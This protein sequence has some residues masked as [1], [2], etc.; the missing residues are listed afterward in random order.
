[1]ETAEQKKQFIQSSQ[2]FST[3]QIYEHYTNGTYYIFAY[4]PECNNKLY[5]EYGDGYIYNHATLTIK[6]IDFI[7]TK[8]ENRVLQHSDWGELKKD[9]KH[10]D[11]E[12]VS[13]ISTN[14]DYDYSSCISTQPYIY[15]QESWKVLELYNQIDEYTIEYK[16]IQVHAINTADGYKLVD[17][18]NIEES[19]TEW[20]F[21]N[22]DGTQGEDVADNSLIE[23]ID[24]KELADY[25]NA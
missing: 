14:V 19:R 16:A 5:G 1:M 22:T 13:E 20:V 17:L 21:I 23:I 15:E 11:V 4:V 6:P 25:K 18:K 8:N 3:G 10:V 7:Q 9:F 2:A 12:T 24:Y